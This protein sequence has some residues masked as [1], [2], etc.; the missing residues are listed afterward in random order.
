MQA[1]ALY[2]T[3]IGKK[4]IM[5]VTGVVWIGFVIAHLYGNLKA[6]QGRE[7][8]DH[9]AEGLRTLGEPIFGY[10]HLLT[11][12]R[13]VL[14]VALVLHV[15]AAYTLFVQARRARPTNYAA[16]RIVQANYASLTM[17]WGGTVILLFLLFHLAQ[18]TWGV[19]AISP[20]FVRGAAYD[21]LLAAFQFWPIT[22]LYLLAV[23]AL[24]FHLYHGTWSM[25]QSL[26]ILDRTFDGVV[27]ALA[28]ALAILVPLGFAAVPIAIQLG[29]IS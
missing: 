5:A 17:R 24:G 15:W 9:Y 28:V 18:L 6:F 27:R 14:V 12:V 26:G 10:L 21:N 22:V 4:A 2:R 16:R 7:A 1:V 8:F 11:L 3:T 25:F 20:T 13:I 29:I 19:S 23:A